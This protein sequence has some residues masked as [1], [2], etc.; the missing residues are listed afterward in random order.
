MTDFILDLPILV[1]AVIPAL[2]LLGFYYWRLHRHAS[3]LKILSFWVISFFI[4]GIISG[5]LALGLQWGFDNFALQIPGW[6]RLMRNLVAASWRQAFITIPI[7]E[8]CKLIAFFIPIC[9]FQRRYYFPSRTIFLLG[10]SVCLGFSA[11]ENVVYVFY[12]TESLLDRIIGTPFHIFFS[13]PWIYILSKNILVNLNFTGSRKHFLFAWLN[14]IICHLVVNILATAGEYDRNLQFFS[15]GLFPFLLWMFWRFEQFLCLVQDK[16]ITPLI[17]GVTPQHRYW[18]KG[19]IFFALMLGGNAILGM[20]VLIKIVIPLI[21]RQIFD[22]QILWLI[23]SRAAVNF[24][25]GIIAIGIY[26]YL[27]NVAKKHPQKH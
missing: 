14:S 1:A 4:F 27:R 18:Q 3:F 13:A 24:I 11:Q 10:I 16:P 7:E 15:Y 9:Y 5:L 22:S 21:S 19:L 17:S 26:I 20:F 6:R 8:G 25:F 2:L 12:D 23:F